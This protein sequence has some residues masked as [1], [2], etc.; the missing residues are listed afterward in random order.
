MALNAEVTLRR[1]GQPHYRV[2]VHDASCHGCKV[3]F[4]ER[5]KPDDRAWIKFDGLEPLEALV[6]WIDGF[7]AGLEFV[8]PIHPAVFNRMIPGSEG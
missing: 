4:V 5:P 6:C 2:R 7:V 1:P 8:K 3:E